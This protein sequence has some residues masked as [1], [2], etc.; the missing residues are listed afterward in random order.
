MSEKTKYIIK[1]ILYIV[2]IAIAVY[3]G[4]RYI[5][6]VAIP[7]L[8][9]GLIAW[10]LHIPVAWVNRKLHLPRGI[11]SMVAVMLFGA[12]LLA[13]F[14]FLI[15]RGACEAGMLV[16]NYKSLM[17]EAYT[18]WDGC[19]ER[20]EQIT[21]IDAEG[22]QNLGIENTGNL[23]D[24]MKEKILPC[25]MNASVSSLKGAATTLG[26]IVVTVVAAILTLNDYEKF[27]GYIRKSSYYQKIVSASD[28]VR[29]VGG[30]YIKAELI[31]IG[32][33]SAICVVGL[34][35][36]GNPYAVVVGLFIGLC[37]ALPFIGTGLILIPWLIVEIIRGKYLTAVILGGI[38]I[39]C[40]FVREY[41][42]PKLV[43]KG[44]GVHPLAIIISIYVGLKVYGISGV[45]LG[46]LSAFLIFEGYQYLCKEED[47]A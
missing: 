7:F 27:I 13:P 34:F 39:A 1:K 5:L 37:D 25:I 14:I 15:Y 29:H 18:L 9:A 22:I 21:G 2:G 17:S 45:I 33:I 20:I 6:P 41:V 31:I 38:Y 16:R 11:V 12:V 30:T 8:I 42:E 32:I 23:L 19:C 4:M 28:H 43:G 35:L 24:N 26:I 46:P 10:I 36:I 3:F 40:S 44:L 47:A